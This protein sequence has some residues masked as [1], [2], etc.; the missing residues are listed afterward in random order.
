[1]DFNF[2]LLNKVL[3]TYSQ[4]HI[5]YKKGDIMKERIC[6]DRLNIKLSANLKRRIKIRAEEKEKNVSE[7]IRDL[8]IKDLNEE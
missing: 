5:I 2:F 4:L 8:V 7:Y 6:D 3:T 1:M